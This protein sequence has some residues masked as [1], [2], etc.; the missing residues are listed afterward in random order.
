[1]FPPSSVPPGAPSDDDLGA[2]NQ[3][4]SSAPVHPRSNAIIDRIR[5]DGGDELHPDFGS[6]PAYGIPYVVVPGAQ[7]DVPVR[8]GPDGFAG[9]S[10]FGPAPIPPR[11][12]VEGGSDSHLLVVDRDACELYELYRAE[13]RDGPRNRWLADS[14]AYFDL[15]STSLRPDTFTSADAAGLPIFP[16]LV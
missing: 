11:S 4:I 3:V 14:T 16:G 1:M 7:P 8:I 10:D 2:W 6:N 13:Y 5:A 15:G 12:P 9:E